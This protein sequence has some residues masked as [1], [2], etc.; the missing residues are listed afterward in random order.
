MFEDATV[1]IRSR[2]LKD[3]QYNGQLKKYTRHVSRTTFIRYTQS[4]KIGNTNNPNP[5]TI[6]TGLKSDAPEGQTV[7][8]PLVVSTMN[9]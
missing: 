7:P 9:K 4:Q 8:V 5:Q 3:R 6:L 2:K 1:E